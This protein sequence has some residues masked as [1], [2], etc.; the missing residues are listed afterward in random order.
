MRVQKVSV[1][2]EAMSIS[3]EC[4]LSVQHP[5]SKGWVTWQQSWH[6]GPPAS[7]RLAEAEGFNF[8]RHEADPAAE[9]GNET[10]VQHQPAA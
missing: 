6:G 7:R 3:S 4:R 10:A 8:T 2:L 9:Q 1:S 5:E